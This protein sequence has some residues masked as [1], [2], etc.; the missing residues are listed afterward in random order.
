MQAARHLVAVVV[1]LAAGVEHRQ[2]DFGGRL[3][4]LVLIDRDAAAV[5]DD[6]HRAVDVDRDVDLIAEAGQRLVDRVVDD[7]VDEMM[8][9]R[10]SGRADVHGRPLADRFEPLENLDLVGAVVFAGAWSAVAVVARGDC[11]RRVAAPGSSRRSV[12][13]VPWF[14]VR[15]RSAAASRSGGLVMAALFR[16]AS[17]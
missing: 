16:L 7:F 4:A 2:H 8:Q 11:L 15:S 17:A 1:E 3:A 5:V 13:Y 12:R 10:R 6:G 9:P 14:L